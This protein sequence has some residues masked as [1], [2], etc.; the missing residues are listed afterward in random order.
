MKLLDLIDYGL[1]RLMQ[2][3][4]IIVALFLLA[5]IIVLAVGATRSPDP[6][7]VGC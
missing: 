4:K 3:Y 6:C 7:D 2:E 1:F 5:L